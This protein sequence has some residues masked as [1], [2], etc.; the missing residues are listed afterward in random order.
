MCGRRWRM[1]F[2]RGSPLGRD[3]GV[4]RGLSCN[5]GRFAVSPVRGPHSRRLIGTCDSTTAGPAWGR[6]TFRGRGETTLGSRTER[7]KV[8]QSETPRERPLVTELVFVGDR[9]G[10]YGVRCTG[11]K[12]NSVWDRLCG[13]DGSNS[14]GHPCSSGVPVN[15]IAE[16]RYGVG[17]PPS[18][19]SLV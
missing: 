1:G 12:G 17:T 2:R 11:P 3:P 6:P 8:R 14:P 7:L 16:P 9:A 10:C 18:R 5:D 13:R 4:L 15:T 19:T